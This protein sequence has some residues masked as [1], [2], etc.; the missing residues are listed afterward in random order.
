M[1]P[2]LCASLPT[3]IYVKTVRRWTDEELVL[4]GIKSPL[5]LTMQHGQ[6]VVPTSSTV[7]TYSLSISYA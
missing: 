3:E 4:V 5:Y 2:T 1:M 6:V 7:L